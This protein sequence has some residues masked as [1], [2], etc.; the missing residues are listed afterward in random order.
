MTMGK[1]GRN[2]PPLTPRPAPP[3]GQQPDTKERHVLKPIP[4]ECLFPT[5][6]D[7]DWLECAVQRQSTKSAEPWWA[8]AKNDMTFREMAR[9]IVTVWEAGRRGAG[10]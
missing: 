8:H 9:V 2:S 10:T 1:G 6:R 3:K 4:V 7:L 5:E